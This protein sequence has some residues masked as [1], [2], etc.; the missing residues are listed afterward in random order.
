MTTRGKYNSLFNYREGKKK[1]YNIA[2]REMGRLM[3]SIISFHI[4][5]LEYELNKVI[6]S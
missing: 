4:H 6:L 3:P 2:K 1:G 5:K